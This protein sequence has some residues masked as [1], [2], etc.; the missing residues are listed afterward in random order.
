GYIYVNDSVSLAC[1]ACVFISDHFQI[2]IMSEVQT[3][4][5]AVGYDGYRDR[6][7]AYKLII[8]HE[9]F[10]NFQNRYNK[11][12]YFNQSGRGTPT[13]YSE[14]TARFQETL[15]TYAE[16]TFAK[17]TLVT[18]NDANG[19]NGFDTG[20]S[21]DAGMAAGP[22]GKTYNTCLMWGPWYVT[23]GKDAFL[24]LVREG[25]PAHSPKPNGFSDVSAAMEQA[26][27]KPLAQQLVEFAGSTITGRGRSWTT[28]FGT[29][30]FDW[31]SLFERWTPA[32]LPN[33]K[34]TRTLG[35]GGLMANELTRGAKVSVSGSDAAR[36]YILRDSGGQLTI[37][38]AKDGKATLVQGPKAGERVWAVV[39]RP[40]TGSQSVTLTVAATGKVEPA[41]PAQAPVT[42]T[43]T[44]LAPGVGVRVSGVTRQFIQFQV[45]VGV[46]NS[47]GEVVATYPL[48]ADIDLFLQ[49]QNADGTW[50]DDLGEGVSGSTSGESMSIGRL[51]PGTYRIEVH[52]WAGPPGNQ[53]SVKATFFNSEGEAG[54]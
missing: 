24:K 39:V 45:P 34:Q 31:G 15:H 42:G 37:S 23:N 1:L 21:M 9:M 12:G 44:T 11:P 49:R 50:S 3:Y 32:P 28:W 16:T 52:N 22:F 14:G 17:D 41:L 7:K 4:L 13:S 19:C 29:T 36:L 51:D 10:H 25:I 48:P 8:G 6:E 38:P 2:H 40:A 46:D 35:P 27:G 30:P 18:A 47:R 20:G 5:D 53:V 26:A 33:G 43:V 54:T